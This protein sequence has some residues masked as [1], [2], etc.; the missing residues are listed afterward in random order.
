MTFKEIIDIAEKG[1]T[2]GLIGKVS[3]N[4]KTEDT[5]ARFIHQKLKDTYVD[6]ASEDEQLAE[7]GRVMRLAAFELDQ[8]AN[9]FFNTQLRAWDAYLLSRGRLDSVK[10]SKAKLLKRL[11]ETT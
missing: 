1:F 7:A 4:K 10:D 2:G 8:V 11:K 5:L 3:W 9:V 6:S